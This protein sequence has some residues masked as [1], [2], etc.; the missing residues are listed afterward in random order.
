MFEL[1][2]GGNKAWELYEQGILKIEDIEDDFPLT[3]FQHLQRKGLINQEQYINKEAIKDM[4]SSWQFPLYFFDFETVF[5]AI[6]VLD[7]SRPYQQVPFQYS[8]HILEKDGKLSHKEFLAHPEDFSNGKNP[9]KLLVEQLK[10]DFGT[11]GNIV[12]YNQS[13]E[14]ARLNELANMFPEDAPFLKNLVSRVVDLLPV[15][16]GG[17]CYF[18]EMKNSASIK[19]VL[20]AVAPDF[21][22]RN[23]VIQEGGTASSLY[24]QSILQQK[25][26]E[27]DLAIH[28]LKYCELDTY[29]MVVIY[30]FLLNVV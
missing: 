6:P 1:Y 3:H 10:Q 12:T 9:L 2:R 24:H 16:Q 20:P 7:G 25:F 17:F 15:F 29:A 18:P 21:T 27:E 30:Q 14:V 5:P 26:V 19:S 28:L 4:I 22:Y 8:L 23:L 11:D 13:F